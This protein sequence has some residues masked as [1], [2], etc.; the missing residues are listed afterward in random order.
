MVLIVN[1]CS[2]SLFI[3]S[4][5]KRYLKLDIRTYCTLRK[6]KTDVWTLRNYNNMQLK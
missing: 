6:I 4:L 1:Y 3:H 2:D 5:N